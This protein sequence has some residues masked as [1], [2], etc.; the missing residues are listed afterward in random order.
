ML[1]PDC[2]LEMMDDHNCWQHTPY[3]AYYR[4]L[5]GVANTLRKMGRCACGR[6]EVAYV[7]QCWVQLQ[8]SC[9]RSLS[10]TASPNVVPERGRLQCR[11]VKLVLDGEPLSSKTQALTC[12]LLV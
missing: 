1:T 3:R 9:L 6:S 11:G 7:L 12:V 5:Y 4:G 2:W 10:L 8:L